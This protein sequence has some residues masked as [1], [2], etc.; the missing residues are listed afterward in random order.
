MQRGG[1]LQAAATPSLI[2][3][4]A[5]AIALLIALS[6]AVQPPGSGRVDTVEQALAW[7]RAALFTAGAVTFVVALLALVRGGPALPERTPERRRAVTRRR[8]G[9]GYTLV[10]LGST[11]DDTRAITDAVDAGE[12]VSILGAWSAAHPDE[13]VIIFAADGEPVAFRRPAAAG[14]SRRQSAA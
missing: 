6:M 9:T 7:A 4:C 5:S 2:A 3:A 11:P 1:R 10:A 12:A 13:H 8:T 14:G